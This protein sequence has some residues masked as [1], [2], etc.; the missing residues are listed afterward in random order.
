[1]HKPL[2]NS[3]LCSFPQVSAARPAFSLVELVVSVGVLVLM[4]S[5]AGQV[6]QLTVQSTGQAKA[7]I[8]VNQQLRGL[9]HTLRADLRNLD[10]NR[11]LMVI[12][13][14]PINAYWTFDGREADDNDDPTDGYPHTLDPER[15][16]P[17]N[18]GQ[19]IPPRADILMFFTQRKSSSS[20]NSQLSTTVQ[21]VVYGHA[22]LGEYAATGE[23]TAGPEAFSEDP[24]AISPLPAEGWVLARRNVL[25]SPNDPQVPLITPP[26]IALDD[27]PEFRILRGETDVIENFVYEDKVLTP[28]P[29]GVPGAGRPWYLPEIF[30]DSYAERAV[31]YERSRLDPSPPPTVAYGV[32]HFLLSHCASFKVEWALDPKSAFVGGLLDGEK[33]IFWIDQGARPDPAMLGDPPPFLSFL[34]AANEAEDGGDTPRAQRLRNLVRLRIGGYPP[35]EEYSLEERFGGMDPVVWVEDARWLRRVSGDNRP[36][37]AVFTSTRRTPPALGDEIVQEEIFPRAVR[38]TIDVYDRLRRLDRP[39]RHVIIASVGT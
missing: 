36:N 27:A 8:E 26:P 7:L 11:S 25:I 19:L 23:F 3:T 33:E 21:Q 1:M 18:P 12:Q 35:S 30:L 22:E 24:N 29:E 32:N 20:L 4:L 9:E 38:I 39:V 14:N 17:L 6:M 16:D 34:V 37:I 15:E 2:H 31:P 10:R 5:V 13:G 28:V